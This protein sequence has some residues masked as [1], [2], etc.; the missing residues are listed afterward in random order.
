M[1]GFTKI[2]LKDIS[3]MMEPK[4]LAQIISDFSCPYNA[5]VEDFLRNR[6]NK[7]ATYIPEL[8]KY[9]ITAP[10]IGQLG[11]NYSSG[12]NELITGDELLKLALDTVREAQRI[13]GG[14]VVYIE[15]EDV[16]PLKKF[17]ERNGFVEFDRRALDGDEMNKMS[18]SYLVQ[19]LRYFA[20]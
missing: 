13:L 19:M 17:Y 9:Q 11:K 15:C 14:K 7:F 1:M 4:Q 6:L 20:G 12:Y 10:L 18:G 3:E 5:D 16:A 8:K 2:N